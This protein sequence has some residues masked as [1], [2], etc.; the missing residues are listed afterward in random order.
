MSLQWAIYSFMPDS[1]VLSHDPTSQGLQSGLSLSSNIQLQIAAE[2]AL[3]GLKQKDTSVDG[4]DHT[5]NQPC[6]FRSL[7]DVNQEKISMRFQN[8]IMKDPNTQHTN[9]N[10]GSFL[11]SH[12]DD[13]IQWRHLHIDIDDLASAQIAIHYIICPLPGAIYSD[14]AEYHQLL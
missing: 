14:K 13:F 8:C 5:K 11:K 4:Y 2:L 7:S 10:M 3:K 6:L 1:I 12:P 9:P